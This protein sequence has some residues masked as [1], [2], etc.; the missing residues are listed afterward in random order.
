MRKLKTYDIGTIGC[1]ILNVL[2]REKVIIL[3]N[4]SVVMYK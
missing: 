4:L 3:D 2:L 1:D